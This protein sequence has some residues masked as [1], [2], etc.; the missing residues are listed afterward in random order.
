MYPNTYADFEVSSYEPYY[1]WIPAHKKGWYY[2]IFAVILTPIVYTTFLH[3]AWRFRQVER[4]ESSMTSENVLNFVDSK[5]TSGRTIK[6]FAGTTCS[7]T[8]FHSSC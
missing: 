1:K 7:C 6:L 8:R 5:A 3:N 4:F 2:R